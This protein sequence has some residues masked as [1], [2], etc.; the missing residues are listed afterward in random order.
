MT[1]IED[2]LFTL[3]SKE[4][5]GVSFKDFRTV[6]SPLYKIKVRLCVETI[7]SGVLSRLRV[8]IGVEYGEE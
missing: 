8:S 6:I 3:R 7:S 4:A 1:C 5:I 2:P